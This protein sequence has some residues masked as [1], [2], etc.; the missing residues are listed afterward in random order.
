MSVRTHSTPA[1][2]LPPE[3]DV[4]NAAGSVTIEAV[5]GA[6]AL[7]VLVEALDDAAEQLLDRVEIDT[8]PDDLGRA[9][10][11]TRLRVSVPNRKLFRTPAFAVR[12][13][14]P[15]GARA[16]VAVASADLDVRGRMG[17]LELTGASGDL[18]VEH[19][20]ELQLRSASG[21]ARIGTVD[22]PATIAS[23]SGE[24]RL[25][26][27]RGALEMRTASG[28]I[29]VD[30]TSGDVSLTSASGD[31]EIGA[32][33]CGS[34]QLKT[35]SGDVSVGVVPGLRVWLDLSSVSGRMHSELDDDG[36]TT[37]NG[38]AELSLG[39]RS[40]SGDLRIRRAATAPAG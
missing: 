7:E 32:A 16:R 1:R 33:A 28:D 2:G 3:I 27:V 29:S 8:G 22:G 5:E 6:E 17:R 26:A 35:V 13:T 11:P 10:A 4:R 40:V 15:A 12:V 9:D 24:L 36:A 31:L 25:G 14:T 21:D 37:G 23:A 19:C 18:A 34:L 38:P 30:R 39:L 20:T